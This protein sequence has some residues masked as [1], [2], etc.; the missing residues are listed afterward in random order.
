MTFWDTNKLNL[1]YK[2]LW[3]LSVQSVTVVRKPLLNKDVEKAGEI[4]PIQANCCGSNRV[5]FERGYCSVGHQKVPLNLHYRRSHMLRHTSLQQQ[6]RTLILPPLLSLPCWL[7]S[8]SV[9]QSRNQWVGAIMNNVWPHQR[10]QNL[11][12]INQNHVV[13]YNG[14]VKRICDVFPSLNDTFSQRKDKSGDGDKA[15]WWR[16]TSLR[17]PEL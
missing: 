8:P 9:T 17:E 10:L 12:G 1:E 13:Y 4:C 15:I 6:V 3:K 5:H 11:R 2:M 14:T 16:G 7:L